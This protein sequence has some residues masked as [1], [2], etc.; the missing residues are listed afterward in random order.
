MKNPYT[1]GRNTRRGKRLT[2]QPYTGCSTS[3]I[4]NTQEN[5]NCRTKSF[6][7]MPWLANQAISTGGNTVSR[8]AEA[9][10]ASRT[11]RST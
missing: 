7:A 5:R 3:M 11:G 1:A 2:S 9:A 8:S 10:M 6:N 4:T